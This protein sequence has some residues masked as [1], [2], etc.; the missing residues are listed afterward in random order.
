MNTL[1]GPIVLISLLFPLLNA[2]GSKTSSTND[3]PHSNFPEASKFFVHGDPEELIADTITDPSGFADA[4]DYSRLDRFKMVGRLEFSELIER[5]KVEQIKNHEDLEARNSTNS[6][7]EKRSLPSEYV[8][9][10]VGESLI[11]RDSVE[12]HEDY[13][14]FTFTAKNH[15]LLL[16]QVDGETVE[17]VHYSIKSDGQ[18][19]SFLVRSKGNYGNVLSAYYFVKVKPL[20]KMPRFVA[21]IENYFLAGNGNVINW[22]SDIDLSVCGKNRLQYKKYVEDSIAAWSEAGAF[23]KGFVGNQAYSVRINDQA[24]PFNDLNQNCVSFIDRYKVED[25]ENL[26]TMGVTI[27]IYDWSDQSIFNSQIFIFMNATK[28]SPMSVMSVLTHEMGHLLGL[29]H[30]FKSGVTDV[31]LPSI[32]GY[33]AEPKITSSDR[34]AINYLYAD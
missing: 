1:R 28:R 18:A 5:S 27:P 13:P 11:Y 6:S 15:R 10:K 16:S 8:F 30:E 34:K 19:I 33:S 20:R 26:L 23:K 21:A 24:F 31:A 2:C 22:K 9:E 25:Q 3:H 32:M 12:D 17:P 7:S 29:G 4:E 14:V